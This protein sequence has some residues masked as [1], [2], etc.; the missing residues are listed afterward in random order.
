MSRPWDTKR[1]SLSPRDLPELRLALWRPGAGLG[2]APALTSSPTAPSPALFHPCPQCP[3][4][5]PLPAHTRR[6]VSSLH[7]LSLF[8]GPPLPW[9]GLKGWAELSPESLWALWFLVLY[10]SLSFSAQGLIRLYGHFH[11][12]H[13]HSHH[14]R[15][16]PEKPQRSLACSGLQSWP[17]NQ[18]SLLSLPSPRPSPPCPHCLP[19]SE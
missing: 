1:V 12:L 11:A 2:P 7:S 9:G 14:R 5:S 15:V 4:P 16:S 18:G 19:P 3:L 17:L 8:L 6:A 13:R 10:I